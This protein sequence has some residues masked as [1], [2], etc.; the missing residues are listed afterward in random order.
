LVATACWRTA[1]TPRTV[2][3]PVGLLKLRNDGNRIYYGANTEHPL[4]PEIR[5]IVE[6][7]CGV[8]ASLENA[9]AGPG[10]E[11]AFIFGSVGAGR[12]RPDSDLDLFVIGD[13]GL[14]NLVKRLVGISERVGRV[15]NSHVIKEE[16]FSR[17]ARTK[18]HFVSNVLGAERVFV[19]GSE[20]ELRRLV[21]K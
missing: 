6:K 15:V 21:K 1:G 13:I 20:D 18:D 7:T 17:K 16:E 10:V 3:D 5:G 2:I 11:I 9:L 4:F 19:I 8:S 12:A 14:R